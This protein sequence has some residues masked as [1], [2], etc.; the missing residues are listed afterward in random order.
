MHGAMEVLG[1]PVGRDAG[2]IRTM[3]V[4][5][6]R[7]S[8]KWFQRL[9]DNG[10]VSTQVAVLLLRFCG[11]PRLNYL[12]RTVKPSLTMAGFRVFD[13]GVRRCFSTITGVDVAAVADQA[14]ADT[15]FQFAQPIRNGGFGFRSYT[16]ASAY[17]YV[18]SVVWAVTR[19]SEQMRAR[20]I[21]ALKSGSS[22]PESMCGE[23]ATQYALVLARCAE[24]GKIP[25]HI[26][27]LLKPSAAE[28]VEATIKA[29]ESEEGV[30]KHIQMK[31][32]H[33]AEERDLQ[34]HIAGCVAAHK[35]DDVVRINSAK[36]QNASRWMTVMPDSPEMRIDNSDYT[37]ACRMRLNKPVTGLNESC[38]KC[39]C[40]RQF[41]HYSVS[42]AHHLT[43]CIKARG[44]SLFHRH[45]A[46]VRAIKDIATRAGA[47]VQLNVKRLDLAKDNRQPDLHLTGVGLDLVT[48]V[49]VTHTLRA[50]IRSHSLATKRSGIA[51][52]QRAAQK[53]RKYKAVFSQNGGV[54]KA[55]A[56][57]TYG[58]A[59][60]AAAEV[61]N[62]LAKHAEVMCGADQRQ[63][64]N[65]AWNLVSASLQRGNGQALRKAIAHC[66]ARA[67]RI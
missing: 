26:S 52:A 25:E 47:G 35:I 1:A 24:G 46:V 31:L 43:L 29:L 38:D 32:T 36:A 60:S 7:Q 34:N 28:F 16:R 3:V 39:V 42:D 8:D 2:K 66:N 51:A 41:S 5:M 67:R 59:D 44:S 37:T 27:S 20:F 55:F 12:S 23:F 58:A 65:W 15:Q 6:V 9:S 30:P 4:E 11:L 61:I 48:D 10:F 13:N 56:L 14:D 63:F 18:A 21:G 19:M 54:F 33:C 62:L 53:D 50:D 22:S 49:V 64:A 57:E 45:Q 17:A 40:G